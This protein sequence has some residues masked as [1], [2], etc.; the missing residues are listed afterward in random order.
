M[1]GNP[2]TLWSSVSKIAF[3]VHAL[4]HNTSRTKETNSVDLCK[5]P[6]LYEEEKILNNKMNEIQ[7]LW[8]ITEVFITCCDYTQ[9]KWIQVLTYAIQVKSAV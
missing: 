2:E 5:E 1:N 8:C 9:K 6:K 3:F 7:S 4:V